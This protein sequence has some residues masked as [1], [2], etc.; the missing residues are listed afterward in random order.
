FCGFLLTCSPSTEGLGRSLFGRLSSLPSSS[1]S[2]RVRIL[3]GLC[4]KRGSSS[5]GAGS[6]SQTRSTAFAGLFFCFLDRWF[7]LLSFL[8][9]ALNSDNTSWLVES[10]GRGQKKNQAARDETWKFLS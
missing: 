8:D 10:E 7:S 4:S 2:S 5:S 3:S 6:S 1:S 9:N